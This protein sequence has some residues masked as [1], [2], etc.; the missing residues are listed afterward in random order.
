[1]GLIE[2]S[3]I[4]RRSERRLSLRK[5]SERPC[6]IVEP[7]FIRKGCGLV[8]KLLPPLGHVGFDA[9]G[10]HA[11]AEVP[12]LMR[13]RFNQLPSVRTRK[14]LEKITNKARMS[15]GQTRNGFVNQR[16]NVLDAKIVGTRC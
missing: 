4:D 3:Q 7:W 15:K 10:E 14:V 8:C 9:T 6:E 2:D 16:R 1:M 11:T 13:K 5:L 12:C